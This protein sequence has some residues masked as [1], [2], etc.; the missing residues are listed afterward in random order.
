M[1]ER[2]GVEEFRRVE[3]RAGRVTRAEPHGQARVPAYKLW[4]DFGDLGVLQSSAQLT[5]L[6]SAAELVDR[7]VLAVTNL[8]PLLVAGFTSQ[9]LVLGVP[10]ADGSQVPLVGP[11]RAVEPGSRVC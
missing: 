9:V 4:I 5:A 10:S 6:Y 11:D 3:I 7:T 8:P 2:I 1:T